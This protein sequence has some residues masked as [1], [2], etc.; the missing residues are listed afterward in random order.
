MCP[1]YTNIYKEQKM[2]EPAFSYDNLEYVEQNIK[3]GGSQKIA[4][5]Q[6]RYIDRAFSKK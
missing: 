6:V 4:Q 5:Y 1:D 2:A 3:D